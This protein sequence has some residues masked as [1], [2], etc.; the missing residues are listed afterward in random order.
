MQ[1]ER[2]K[3]GFLREQ[4]YSFATNPMPLDH[5]WTL[6]EEVVA[7]LTA[8]LTERMRRLDCQ[9]AV[10]NINRGST[11]TR[12]SAGSKLVAQGSAKLQKDQLC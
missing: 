8:K 12:P 9:L 2:H 7:T 3:A 5:L 4:T 10:L 11:K 6:H 1:R